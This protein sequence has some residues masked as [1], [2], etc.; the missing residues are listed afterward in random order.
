MSVPTVE[1]DE[2]SEDDLYHYTSAGGL[3]G[4]LEGNKF[5]ATHAAYLNDSQEFTYGMQLLLAELEAADQPPPPPPQAPENVT[6]TDV[7]VA[8]VP[9]L[10]GKALRL[11]FQQRTNFLRQNAG[12]FVTCLSAARDQLSQWRGYGTGGGYAI[13]FDP[14]ALR[15]S[16]TRDRPE[17]Q[18]PPEEIFG[19]PMLER[20][21]IK[22]EYETSAQIRQVHEQVTQFIKTFGEMLASEN[23]GSAGMPQRVQELLR[24]ELNPLLTA[25]LGL[26]TRLKH[27]GFREEQEYRIVVFS[28]PEFFGPNDI[29]LIPRLNITFNP[30]CIKEIMIG[31]GQHMD[32]RESSVRA[33]LQRHADRYPGV[34][35]TRSE[36][37]F[38]GR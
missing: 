27:P 2:P 14:Q 30:T 3:H 13:R 4:I 25:A 33:Y 20:R 28:P 7:L 37:P 12:P 24:T 10:L 6:I 29:G 21:L 23:L 19:V 11:H 36:T 17:V 31:P 26:T 34:E 35:V 18:T 22:M 9:W 1:E 38:T 15:E 5:W 16:L 32:T 8:F